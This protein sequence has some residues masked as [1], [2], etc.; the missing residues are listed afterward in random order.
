M[1]KA[2]CVAGRSKGTLAVKRPYPRSFLH[3]RRNPWFLVS[4]AIHP[5]CRE[6]RRLRNS[7]RLR[8][9]FWLVQQFQTPS[10]ACS[11]SRRRRRGDVRVPGTQDM[12]KVRRVDD[13]VTDYEA[14]IGGKCVPNIHKYRP[15]TATATVCASDA[16]CLYSYSVQMSKSKPTYSSLHQLATLVHLDLEAIQNR[17]S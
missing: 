8:E 11:S 7:Y 4:S 10:Y 3:T 13:T 16:A 14:L 17:G 5:P 15:A 2:S 6:A 1:G 9:S 12:T